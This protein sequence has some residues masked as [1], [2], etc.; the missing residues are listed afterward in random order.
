MQAPFSQKTST[1][2]KKFF[3]SCCHWTKPDVIML[4]ISV[5]SLPAER[6]KATSLT[7]RLGIDIESGPGHLVKSC[8]VL[9]EVSDKILS[10]YSVTRLAPKK[11]EDLLRLL[12]P[13]KSPWQCHACFKC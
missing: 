3:L 11:E 2:I 1:D 13:H 4:R 7:L 5:H 9:S 10:G 8:S 12:S 6:V